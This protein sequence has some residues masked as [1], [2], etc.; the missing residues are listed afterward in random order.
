[1][2]RPAF[3]WLVQRA[4]R[5]LILDAAQVLFARDGFGSTGIRAIA[6]EVGIS[7]ATIYH[8]F[9]SKE[10]IMD[11]IISRVSAG[12]MRGYTFPTDTSLEEVLRIVGSG[13]L[14]AMATAGNREL[15]HL[16]LTESAHDPHRAERYLSEI[17]DQG[18]HALEVAISGLLPETSPASANTISKM[19]SGA[20][21]HHVVHN[22]SIAAVAGRPL[23]N[24]VDPTRWQYLEEIIAL[25]VRGVGAGDASS[26]QPA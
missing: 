10:D 9:R 21:V 16:M 15:I 7:E 26:S 18:V 17:S 5:D 3:R 19:L 13:F 22:E 25:I 6:A 2:V 14:Q 8:Y 24:G 23:E 1:M 20:L 12:Q 4:D 11:A